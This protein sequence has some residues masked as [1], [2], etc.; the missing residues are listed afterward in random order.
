MIAFMG[1]VILAALDCC[2]LRLLEQQGQEEFKKLC[3][4]N[5][6]WFSEPAKPSDFG[7]RVS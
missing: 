3:M 1:G 7:V 4:G 5:S 6:S 2:K